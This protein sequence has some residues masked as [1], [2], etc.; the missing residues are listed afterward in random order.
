M[1]RIIP[2]CIV[3]ILLCTAIG[4]VAQTNDTK[5]TNLEA[6]DFTHTVFAEDAT[7]TW[8]GYCHYARE[9][10]D[11]IYTSQDYPFYYICLVDDKNTHAAARIDEYNIYGFPTV[12]FDYG[13]KVVV[14]GWTGAE[15]AYRTAINQCGARTVANIDVNLNVAWQGNA[16]MDISVDVTNNEA[17]PYVGH[18]HVYVC[19]IESSLGWKDTMNHAYT[20][21]FLDYAFNEGIT[22]PVGETYSNSKNWDGHDYNSGM[23][24]TF[25]SIQY[26]NIAVIAAVFN[27]TWHQGYAYPPSSNPF[28]AYYVDDTA[29]FLVAD[30]GPFV[31][32]NPNPA[33]GAVNVDIEKDLSWTGGGSPGTTITYDVYFGTAA[34][35]PIAVHNQSATTYNPGT[36]AYT[37]KY[38][39]KI[40]AWDQNQHSAAGPIW[41]F[42][43]I[44]NPNSPP[45]TP[46]ITGPAKGAPGSTY[47]Y[48]ITG[49]DPDGDMVSAYIVWGD[50]T[51]TDWTEFHDSGEA[52][53][54]THSWAEKG[55]YTVQ[56]KVK[57]EAGAESDWATLEVKMPTSYE[58]NSPFL[59]WLLEHFPNAFPILRHLLGV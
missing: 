55:T 43:T 14:G 37:T 51:I 56:V 17:T 25:G 30:T 28:N 1:K 7:A 45:D 2:I 18:L 48:T 16:V 5:S 19:E 41:S 11:A 9:A 33:N 32:Y 52:F 38:Y 50:D 13:Y 21:P 22:I 15:A 54:I 12:F 23:G 34:T 31:P 29:G 6:K 4:A 35:P 58:P 46:T 26:G 20:F 27:N 47:K 36:L 57:D 24:Q 59:H 8:C 53:S 44:T 40:V 3:G 10:L 49:T 42:T 39:W